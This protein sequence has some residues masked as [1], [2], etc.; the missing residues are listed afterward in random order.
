MLR[1]ACLSRR[2]REE[3]EKQV[4][5]M[6]EKGW[7]QP[8]SS[9]Y[10]AP[11]LFVPKPNG[12][13]RMCID[14]RA[15]NK[16]TI[17]SKYASGRSLGIL[18]P[19]K[20]TNACRHSCN[21]SEKGCTDDVHSPSY[22]LD[23]PFRASICQ[24]DARMLHK[25]RPSVQKSLFSFRPECCSDSAQGSVEQ[26]LHCRCKLG[27]ISARHC[28]PTD[29]C[30]L[31][32]VYCSYGKAQSINRLILQPLIL[33]ASDRML[34]YTPVPAKY[35]AWVLRGPKCCTQRQEHPPLHIFV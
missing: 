8:S 3:L 35:S 28:S 20:T 25:L 19:K 31:S 1:P 29:G 32:D 10:G 34:L 12:S 24:V 11:V 4:Q 22:P 23:I 30:S 16:I 17:K 14:Y 7:T 6:L 18:D 33:Y 13:M 27:N 9:P 2:E 26:M 5:G 15:L 21:G